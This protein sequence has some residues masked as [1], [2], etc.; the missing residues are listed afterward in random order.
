MCSAPQTK[1]VNGGAKEKEDRVG[2]EKSLEVFPIYQKDFNNVSTFSILVK[3][4]RDLLQPKIYHHTACLLLGRRDPKIR[5]HY[6]TMD[7]PSSAATFL[8]SSEER[9]SL[10]ELHFQTLTVCVCLQKACL[11]A[12]HMETHTHTHAFCFMAEHD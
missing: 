1:I 3:G 11:V 10:T 5:Y 7:R 12:G 8:K 2:K 9:D 6:K 4:Q